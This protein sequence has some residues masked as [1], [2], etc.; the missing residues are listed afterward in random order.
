MLRISKLTDYALLIMSQM[1]K[2]PSS[3]L[4]AAQIAQALRLNAPTVSKILKMLSEKQLVSSIRGSIGGYHLARAPDLITVADIISAMEN[5]LALT[6]CTQTINHCALDSVCT[7]KENWGKINTMI[8]ALLGS[9]T[10]QDMLNP[11]KAEVS[12]A[13]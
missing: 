12:D 10:L 11:L 2:T 7:M 13:K 8:H 5:K 6:E 4:S 9:F 1:A 3:V